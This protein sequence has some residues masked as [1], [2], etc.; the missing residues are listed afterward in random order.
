[1]IESRII[2]CCG[3][4][5][6]VCARLTNGREIYPHRDDLAELPFWKCDKCKNY[7]GC[8]YK[9]PNRTNPLGYIP[10]REI[11]RA[12]QRLHKIIDPIWKGGTMSRRDVYGR[13]SAAIGYTYHSGEIKSVAEAD[14]IQ[15]IVIEFIK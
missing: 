14:R 10:T 6:D 3:C 15:K 2:Y 5:H 13:I 12:R 4:N 1:M 9:T 7:V 8:H 11:M